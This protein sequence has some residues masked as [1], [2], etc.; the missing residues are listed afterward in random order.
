MTTFVVSL[1]LAVSQARTYGWDSTYILTLLAI[2]SVN[3]MAFVGAELTC[4]A[5][6]VNLQVFANGQF[7]LG[8]LAN[9]CESFTNFAMNFLMALFLQQALGLNAQLAGEIML[10]AACIWGLTSLG[11]GRL[12]DR[13]ESRWLIAIGS[14]TQA[15][16]LCLFLNVTPWS[17]AWVVS[18]LLIFRSLTRGFIQSPIMTVTMATLPDHQVRLGAGLRGLLNSLGGT[19]GIAFAGIELQQRLAVRTISLLE[20]EHRASFEYTQLVESLQQRFAET[21]E[22]PALLTVQTEAMLNRWLVQEATTL[23]YHDMF[24]L[25]AVLVLLTAV[26]VL[27]LRQ[28]RGV[29]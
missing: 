4:A 19:F 15:L 25:T 18:G 16:A 22:D 23:A 21:G 3:L 10:P 24:L 29:S 8:A 26:P 12:S 1:L 13:I 17:S 20:N 6:L 2:A 7:V 5:P 14:L 9:F 11:T 27:W 28:R